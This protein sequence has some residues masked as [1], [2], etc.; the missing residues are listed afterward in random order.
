MP[1]VL[2]DQTTDAGGAAT[3]TTEYIE[4]RVQQVYL[5]YQVGSAIGTT[6]TITDTTTGSNIFT[7]PGANVNGLFHPRE[8]CVDNANAAIYYDIAGAPANQGEVR[9]CYYVSG[10]VDV[11]IAGAGGIFNILVYIYY[12]EFR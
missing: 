5:D 2:V 7:M 1:Y 9:D 6:I 8:Q 11:V 12:S 3:A 10:S 4:G